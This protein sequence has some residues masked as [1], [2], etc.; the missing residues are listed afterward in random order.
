M[1]RIMNAYE[2]YAGQYSDDTLSQQQN[3]NAKYRK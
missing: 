3:P 1:E 2:I